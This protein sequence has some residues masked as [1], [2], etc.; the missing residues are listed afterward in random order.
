MKKA[1]F[2]FITVMLS[3]TLLIVLSIP[4]SALQFEYPA[5]KDKF[6]INENEFYQQM[7]KKQYKE[8]KDA[9]YSVRQ[10]ILYKETPDELMTFEKKTGRYFGQP[11][12]ELAPF[13]HP[14]R[15]VYFLASFIQTK[16]KEY[17]KY[18][19]IDAESKR[20]LEGGNSYHSYENP[21]K[22]SK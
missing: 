15:Q 18:T 8:Y 16:D 17:W 6:F 5:N 20:Q 13:I 9:T 4:T 21:Y 2:L 7:D 1:A 12:Q 10:K 11:K 3:F 19:I 14:E 22:S